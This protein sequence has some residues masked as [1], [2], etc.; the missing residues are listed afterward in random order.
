MRARRVCWCRPCSRPCSRAARQGPARVRGLRG[1]RP[2]LLSLFRPA[3][4][5]PSG[6]RAGT[7]TRPSTAIPPAIEP[8]ASWLRNGDCL[9]GRRDLAGML[10]RVQRPAPCRAATAAG[11]RAGRWSMSAPSPAPATTSA[12]STTSE[13]LG[14]RAYSLGT[15]GVGRRIYV[16]PM[17][18]EA[19]V[20][21]VMHAAGRAGFQHPYVKS[22]RRAHSS[23]ASSRA[24]SDGAR[25]VARPRPV[26]AEVDDDLREGRRVAGEPFGDAPPRRR[27]SAGAA[28]LSALV[29][30]T[31]KVTAARSSRSMISASS[32][33]SPWRASTAGT[34][35]AGSGGRRGRRA[36]AP[37]SARP[38]PSAPRR[39]RSRAGRP[40]RAARRARRS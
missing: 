7:S 23:A 35:A 24:A 31:W 4:T 1:R 25:S 30:T 10:G 2:Q 28:S 21:A 29:S 9:T 12:R 3:S 18:T 32:G 33:F 5:P 6:S 13:A 34:P 17:A 22:T 8:I 36:S 19:G 15:P 26:S 27:A 38:R 20:A 14:Y 39:S 16:G 40:D 37:A 11:A